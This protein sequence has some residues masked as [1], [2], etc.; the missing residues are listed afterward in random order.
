MVFKLIEIMTFEIFDN[1]EAKAIGIN[2]VAN[3]CCVSV[4]R[5]RSWIEK[6]LLKS[7]L[8]LEFG[9]T[10]REDLVDFLMQYN[11]PIPDSILPVKA[12]KILFIFSSDTLEYIYV[13][14]L[15]NF[16]DK[17]KKEEN[18]ISDYVSYGKN[19][20]YKIL[21]FMPDLIITD[22]IGA[23]DESIEIINFAKDIGSEKLLSI[24]EKNETIANI[25]KIKRAGADGVVER[26]IDIN[27]LT[28]HIRKLF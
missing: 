5:V 23:F 15:I 3:L 9:K 13:S 7:S 14:F 20:K 17:L 22:T 24:V 16:F 19:A 10:R 2:Q 25:D 11:M 8:S 6:G 18:F 28:R 26:C 27:E 21:T 12:K 4:D 1:Y